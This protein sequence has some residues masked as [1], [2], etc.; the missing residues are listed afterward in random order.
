[1]EL[2][3]LR[4]L[5][6]LALLP[7]LWQGWRRRR[8]RPL[9]APA[10]GAYLLPGQGRTRPWLWLA[11]L[12]VILALSGP[13]LRQ[14]SQPISSPALDI[15]L[16]DLSDSMLAGDLPPDRAT[17][18]RL[19][20][21]DMLAEDGPHP[22]ALILFAGDA[23]LAMPATR[24]HQA[25]SLLL[26]DLRPAIMPLPG[27]APERAVAL[28][29]SQIPAGQQAR[30]LL[31]TDG[32]SPVQ[33]ARIAA[34]WPCQNALLCPQSAT[35]RLDILL[36]NGGKAA[37]LPPSSAG[38]GRELPPPDGAAMQRLAA[39]SG[40][41]L[42]WLQAGVPRFAPLPMSQTLTANQSRDLGPWLLLPLLP[43]ALLARIGA[44]WLLLLGVSV[45]LFNP[46]LQASPASPP[47]PNLS[48]QDRQAWQAFQQG[49]YLAAARDFQDPVWQGN[50]WYRAG[51]YARAVAAYGRA[52]SVTAHYNRG[53]ALVQLGDLKGA[54]QA[55]LATLALEPGHEDAL[56]NLALLRAQPPQAA[57]TAQQ[58]QAA[59][60]P[61]QSAAPDR[62]RPPAPPVLLLEQRLRKEAQR[63]AQATP[64]LKPEEPW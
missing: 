49:R 4:P 50:A 60:A 37:K 35:P 48:G 15:W 46:P 10:M 9:L 12:P 47:I 2:I 57:P 63:R 25:I 6:L 11:C 45:G 26:P 1:M 20:L 22:V 39:Q 44:L 7:W 54:E 52:T 28:A 51:D 40:G 27:S 34:Q 59:D 41:E 33:I 53:N 38:L 32:L 16:L 36:A 29:L 64:S 14:Q 8:Q 62:P 56:Y 23:Y 30:L 42:Q 18:V 24:D 19:L 17:R 61:E 13:A 3:L 58:P 31:I 21:Q 55:Y 5:W 43:L